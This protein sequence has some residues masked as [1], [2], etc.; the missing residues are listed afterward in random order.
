MK[1]TMSLRLT[2]HNGLGRAGSSL[3]LPDFFMSALQLHN[4]IF[5]AVFPHSWADS[6]P[7]SASLHRLFLFDDANQ[8]L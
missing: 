4:G 7:L 3:N 6:F 2:R 8:A 1:K 5:G